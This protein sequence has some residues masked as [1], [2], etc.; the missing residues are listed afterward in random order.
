MITIK[1]INYWPSHPHKAGY[2]S[3]CSGGIITYVRIF[4][5]PTPPPNL[6]IPKFFGKEDCASFTIMVRAKTGLDSSW[7]TI[8]NIRSLSEISF[9]THV[10]HQIRISFLLTDRYDEIPPTN[11][12]TV[13]SNYGHVEILPTNTYVSKV[14]VSRYSPLT[15]V[16]GHVWSWWD[17]VLWHKHVVKCGHVHHMKHKYIQVFVYRLF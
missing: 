11:T 3:F 17:I 6:R 12:N 9:P 4:K 8:I 1:H 2:P 14:V 13:L 7:A 15:Q 16:H 5:P 10:P